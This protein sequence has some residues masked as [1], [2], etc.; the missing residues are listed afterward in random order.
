M[1][2]FPEK[3]ISMTQRVGV[4][5]QI[6]KVANSAFD[7]HGWMWAAGIEES[8]SNVVFKCFSKLKQLYKYQSEIPLQTPH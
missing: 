7:L 3:P 2:V 1:W 4:G 8:F 5:V 6:T